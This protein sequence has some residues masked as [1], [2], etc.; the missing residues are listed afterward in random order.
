MGARVK[1][2]IAAA[3]P[4]VIP[5][6]VIEQNDLK[7]LS[8]FDQTSENDN[9]ARMQAQLDEYL[10][11]IADLEVEQDMDSEMIIERF[12]KILMSHKNYTV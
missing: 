12:K 10:L 7:Q 2:G 11:K 5:E 8:F 6:N 9:I 3:I 1:D 4:F